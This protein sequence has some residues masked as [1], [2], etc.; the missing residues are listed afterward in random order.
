MYFP[1]CFI[2]LTFSP[3]PI[4]LLNKLRPSASHNAKKRSVKKGFRASALTQRQ[5]RNFILGDIWE[6]GVFM[7]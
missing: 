3:F 4:L 2:E 7:R 1:F 6:K 5:K